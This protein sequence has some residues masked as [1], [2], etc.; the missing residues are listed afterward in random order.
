METRPLVLL[1]LLVL[2]QKALLSVAKTFLPI[3]L[4][5]MGFSGLQ[6]GFLF[7]LFTATALVSY[8]P[9]GLVNDRFSIRGVM[10][11]G[12]LLV[13]LFMFG[14]SGAS[15]SFHLLLALFLIGGTG[16]NVFE[17]SAST[18]LLKKND[19]GKIFGLFTGMG[20]LGFAVGVTFGG[21]LLLNVLFRD[22]FMS[23]GAS[24][25]ILAISAFLLPKT[26]KFKFD[27][28]K[29]ERDF[30]RTEISVFILVL[31]LWGIHGGA[32]LTSYTLFLRQCFRLDTFAIGSYMAVAE[33]GLVATALMVGWEMDRKRKKGRSF[34]FAAFLALGLLLSGLGHVLMTVPPDALTSLFFRFVHEAGDG[35][36]M[37][38]I[39]IGVRRFFDIRRRGGSYGFVGTVTV[40]GAVLGCM[41]FGPV[42]EAIGYGT[43]LIISGIPGILGAVLVLA[44]R[45]V[46]VTP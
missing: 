41:A 15:G 33:L 7:A 18:L 37:V 45:R 9:A 38:L 5:G 8:F 1:N 2:F 16:M 21:F 10:C 11:A 36:V 23:I 3:L 4:V 32:E 17:T 44:F 42:G 30:L 22:L 29:Y 28:A 24:F 13:A 31:F 34:N 26:R 43:P 14:I 35:M 40:A 39:Y 12:L 19:S 46:L 20:A 25:L 6:I 27:V